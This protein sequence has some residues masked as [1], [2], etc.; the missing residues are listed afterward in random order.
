[1]APPN[2]VQ[3]APTRSV[4]SRDRVLAGAIALADEVG[5]SGFTIRKLATAIDVRPMTIYHHVPNKEAII[6]GMIDLIFAEIELPPGGGDWK[7]AMQ[8]RARSARAVLA[9]HPWATPLME[10]RT[11]PGPATLNHHDEVLRCLRQAGFSIR[12][13]AHAYALIDSYIYGFA[14]Q[15]ANLPAT[16]GEDMA[17]VAQGITATFDG[18]YPH[19]MELTTEHVLKPGYDFSEEFEFGLTLILDGLTHQTALDGAMGL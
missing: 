2:S 7:A 13:T 14:L 10:S 6:D 18:R 8:H 3:A 15:E 11:N 16:G 4:L 17:A 19:L 5:I 1:M 9:H 12:M